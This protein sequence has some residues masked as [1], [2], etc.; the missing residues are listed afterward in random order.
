MLATLHGLIYFAKN[1]NQTGS[2][3]RR[4]A[5]VVTQPPSARTLTK[6]LLQALVV[7]HYFRF[8][9]HD[10]LRSNVAVRCDFSIASLQHL[11]ILHRLLELLLQTAHF[12]LRLLSRTC[13][14]LHRQNSIY[15]CNRVKVSESSTS[16]NAFN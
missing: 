7:A 15:P 13:Q 14:S 11:L 1:K 9:S 6:D 12:C 4:S 2:N 10:T 5:Q 16:Y 3:D 8:G